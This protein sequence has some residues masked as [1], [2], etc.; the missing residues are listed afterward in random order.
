MGGRAEAR[1][2]AA[3]ATARAV[4]LAENVLPETLEGADVFLGT[5]EPE[6]H[7]VHAQVA[8]AAHGPPRRDLAGALIGRH[9]RERQAALD[10]ER[11]GIP[12]GVADHR[13]EAV[14]GGLGG[15]TG[16][17]VRHPAVGEPG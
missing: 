7:G 1:R 13:M 14:H 9:L 4:E 12:A 2:A 15:S 6:A 10:A 16:P 11:R 17:E 8:D 5:R 3:P